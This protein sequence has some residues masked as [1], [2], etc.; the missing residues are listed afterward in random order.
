[1]KATLTKVCFF[2]IKNSIIIDNFDSRLCLVNLGL[3]TYK[4]FVKTDAIYFFWLNGK[5]SFVEMNI[6]S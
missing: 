5:N 3:E 1:M 2:P 4:Y 6:F